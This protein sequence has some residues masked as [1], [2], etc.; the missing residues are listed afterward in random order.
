VKCA[1]SFGAETW[2]KET[3]HLEE[4]GIDGRATLKFILRNM[5]RGYWLDSSG[6]G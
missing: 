6:S 3:D 5:M 4:Q 1:Q 2:R